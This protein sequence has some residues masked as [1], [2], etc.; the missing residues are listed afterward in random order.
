MQSITRYLVTNKI[1][2]VHDEWTGSNT[3]YDKVYER[4][5]K[6]IKGIQ[7][8]FTFEVKNRDQK[9]VS[10]L[11]TYTPKIKIFDENKALIISKDGVIKET[12]TPNYKGQFT[13][14]INESDTNDIDGQHLSYFVYLV[15]DSDNSQSITYA[16][17]AFNARGN[18][19]VVH[20]VMPGPKDAYTLTTF[21]E[22]GYDTDIYVS[23]GVTA[24][25]SLNGNEA[26]HTAAIYTTNYTGD[27]TIQATLDNQL[28][29]NGNDWVDLQ[30]ITISNKSVPTVVNYTGIY[31]FVRIKH[32]P[33]SGTIDKVLIRN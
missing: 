7:N 2:V 1:V 20:D 8:V 14:T 13:V 4:K 18:M 29:N 30:T 31:S 3:E 32:D 24:E 27:V 25:P 22:T 10:I 9:P 5:L 19:E 16:D 17:T 28:D 15:K 33:T 23:E 26:L 21:T 12:A 6:L 11:N